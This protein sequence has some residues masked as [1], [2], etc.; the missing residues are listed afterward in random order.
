MS[1]AVR[2][3][4]SLSSMISSQ[5]EMD[6]IF[7][8]FQYF[9]DIAQNPETNPRP[10]TAT[11][12]REFHSSGYLPAL[13]RET[14]PFSEFV[15]N[16]PT[17]IMMPGHQQP[18]NYRV[19]EPIPPPWMG[20]HPPGLPS[21]AS[22][23]SVATST[24]TTEHAYA[25]PAR[26]V[27]TS[28]SLERVDPRS[29]GSLVSLNDNSWNQRTA[30]VAS[31]RTLGSEAAVAA[32]ATTTGESVPSNDS[33]PVI[34][35]IKRDFERKQEFL[36]TTNLPN[37]LASPVSEEQQAAQVKG[38]GG[39]TQEEQRQQATA[40][41]YFGDR[42]PIHH[43][44]LDEEDGPGGPLRSSNE[45]AQFHLYGL[46]LGKQNSFIFQPF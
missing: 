19:P 18:Q 45:A 37:Y 25:M 35:R 46:P 33:D 40:P 6:L 24:S 32:L 27:R 44:R 15:N 17:R 2:M 10:A 43:P 12:S 8:N 29:V 3:F 26:V 39:I 38:S 28:E 5:A 34:S 41:V 23:A 20:Q 42:F 14:S 1:A 7:F 11:P 21:N 9:S 30:S 36:R 31:S 4:E 13:P 22:S 16:G